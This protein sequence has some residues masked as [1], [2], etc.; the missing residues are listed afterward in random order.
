VRIHC[1]AAAVSALLFSAMTG[2]A[3][4]LSIGYLS[5]DNLIPGAPGSPGVNIFTIANLTGDPS[6][7]GNDLPPDFPVFT[8]IIFLHSSLE[9]FS[10]RSSQ[11][12]ALGNLSP[13]STTRSLCS[14]RIRTCFPQHCSRPLW[15]QRTC[16]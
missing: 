2:H 12:V 6:S 8:S 15:I 3:G 10:G 16:T 7:G 9:W 5:L 1:I 4:L 13:D 11:T 14:F